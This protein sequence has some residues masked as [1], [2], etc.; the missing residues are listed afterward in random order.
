M[1]FSSVSEGVKVST[2]DIA[3]IYVFSL[4]MQYKK[5]KNC[6]FFI[7]ICTGEPDPFPLTFKWLIRKVPT[8]IITSIILFFVYR[9]FSGSSRQKINKRS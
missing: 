8:E 3:L 2:R 7:S 5:W 1:A 6:G 4:R 9:S